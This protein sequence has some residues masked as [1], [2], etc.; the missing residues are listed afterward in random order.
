MFTTAVHFYAP[1][2]LVKK[3]GLVGIFLFVSVSAWAQKSQTLDSLFGEY[4][5]KQAFA[6]TVLI[7]EKGKILYQKAFGWRDLA[8]KDSLKLTTPMPLASIAKT[9]TGAALV[10]LHHRKQ[11]SYDQ[12]VQHYL[13]DFP[14]PTITLRHLV[15]HTGGL[16]SF[17]ENTLDSLVVYDHHALLKWL[18]QAPPALLSQPG[19]R[20]EYSNLGY[21][22]LACVIE[23]VTGMSYDAF[24]QAHIFSPLHMRHSF[25]AGH[26]KGKEPPALTYGKTWALKEKNVG[27]YLGAIGVYSSAI[28]LYSF[29]QALYTSVLLPSS[30]W[31]ESFKMGTFDNDSIVN[32]SFGWRHW[33]MKDNELFNRGDWSGIRTIFYR[34]L[35]KRRCIIVLANKNTE[36]E[37][38]DIIVEV[39]GVL[40]N[41]KKK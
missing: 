13:T 19:T 17:L 8:L 28:D 40:D 12:T 16:P 33:R 9:F 2:T 5:Q 3:L 24:L 39:L 15:Y 4:I 7:A 26:G 11:I 22:V 21:C 38:S 34:D 14:Y 36:K 27:A 18:I 20:Y 23:K 25:V 1:I 29:D 10:L 32:Q 41:K 37:S 6:G 35:E 30:V 31:K